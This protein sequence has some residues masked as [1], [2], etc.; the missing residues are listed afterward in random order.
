VGEMVIA[1]V[2]TIPATL[3]VGWIMFEFTQLPGAASYVVVSALLF[4][5]FGW[6]G[7]AMSKAMRAEDVAAEIATEAELREPVSATPHL[8]GH[9]TVE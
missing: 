8:E 9:G 6:I 3:V 7:W 1:W 2:I 5:L 4:V